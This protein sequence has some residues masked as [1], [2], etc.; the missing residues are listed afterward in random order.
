MVQHHFGICMIAIII[1]WAGFS[2]MTNGLLM[3]I[4]NQLD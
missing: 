3:L 4:G 1:S 2:L